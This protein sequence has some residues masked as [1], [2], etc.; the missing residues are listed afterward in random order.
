[1]M[2]RAERNSNFELLR[3]VAMA[4]IVFWHISVHAQNEAPMS[5]NYVLAFTI[6]GVNLFVLISG[7]FNIKLK[8]RSLLEILGSVVFYYILSLAAIYVVFGQKPTQEE[9]LTVLTPISDSPW[10]F[11]RCYIELMLLSPLLNI[12]LKN[13]SKGEH[14]YVLGAMLFLGCISGYYFE[15]PINLTGYNTFQFATLY[16]L[17]DAIR[18]FE[19]DKRIAA[20]WLIIVH[21]IATFTIFITSHNN[22]NVRYYN[23][24]FIVTAAF[25]LFSLFAKANIQNRLINRA[26][27]YMLPVYLIQD[28]P[29]GY[30]I[31]RLLYDTGTK[32]NFEGTKYIAV[33]TVYII[34][35][36]TSAF[37]VESIRLW[38][39]KRPL[40]F[41]ARK[42]EIAGQKLTKRTINL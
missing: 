5:N 12:F 22:L 15:N 14:L 7:Y 24:P 3:I 26:A 28:S 20:K 36:L 10:W 39:T 6:T 42:I 19:W 40:D 2:Q 38:L 37:L 30:Y 16:I 17:G 33:L 23:N 29:F 31:Y 41:I 13:S 25:C 1:M 21:I 35:L 18:R 9:W 4:F 11:M 32:M 34:A 8:F 27:T